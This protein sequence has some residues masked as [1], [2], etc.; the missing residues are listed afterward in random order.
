MVGVA[1]GRGVKGGKGGCGGR[2]KED[3]YWKDYCKD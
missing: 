1:L 3:D 2:V